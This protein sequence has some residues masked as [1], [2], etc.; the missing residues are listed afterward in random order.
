MRKKL[1]E[2]LL[3]GKGAAAVACG[4][5]CCA[6]RVTTDALPC[7]GQARCAPYQLLAGGA[8]L[9]PLCVEVPG[10]TGKKTFLRKVRQ[11]EV[12]TG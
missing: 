8:G 7:P 10:H 11:T 1:E 9:P 4:V 3:K 6:V 5:L 12:A 2:I